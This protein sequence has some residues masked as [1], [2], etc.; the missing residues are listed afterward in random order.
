[1]H[2]CLQTGKPYGVYGQPP[3]ST[4]SVF[5]PPWNGKM[6]ISQKPADEPKLHYAGRLIR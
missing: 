2:D 5:Y 4:R 3:W 6:S 1:M